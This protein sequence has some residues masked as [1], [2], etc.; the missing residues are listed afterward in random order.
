MCPISKE[1]LRS[2][3]YGTYQKNGDGENALE[4]SGNGYG[5]GYGKPY[6]NGYGNG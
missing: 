5:N 1:V 4:K 6:G 2:H 3:L